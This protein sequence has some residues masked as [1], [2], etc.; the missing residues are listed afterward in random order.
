MKNN[1]LNRFAI[2]DLKTHKKD[3]MMTIVTIFIAAIIIMMI[4]FMTPLITNN[5]FLEY[6]YENGNY[7]YSY[8]MIDE[9][10]ND[11]KQDL[12]KTKYMI[13]GQE[14]TLYDLSY[15]IEYNYARTLHQEG[16]YEIEGDSSI[17]ATR[18][19]EGRMPKNKSE[20]AVKKSVLQRWGYGQKIGDFIQLSYIIENGYQNNQFGDKVEVHQFQVVGFLEETGSHSIIVSGF[21]QRTVYDS[22][23]I[24]TKDNEMIDNAD[25][26]LLEKNSTV[27]DFSNTPTNTVIIALIQT[28]IIIIATVLIYGLTL[29]SFE[30]KQKDYTLLRSIG[31]TQRQIYYV[32]MVQSLLLSVIP[33]IISIALIY[34][35]SKILPIL[36]SLPIALPF[37]IGNVLW[38]TFIILLLVFAS[39]FIP[40]RS[41]T[42]QS[43][44]GTFEGQEF[45]YFYYRYKKLHQLRPFYLAWRQLIA[46]KKKMITKIIMIIII[47]IMAFQIPS[48]VLF[49]QQLKEKKSNENI[50]NITIQCSIDTK[51]SQKQ[52]QEDFQNLKS[53]IQSMISYHYI[54]SQDSPN[55]YSI[56]CA[57]QQIREYYHLQDV[58]AG[59]IIVSSLYLDSENGNE[60]TKNHVSFLGNEYD[61]I[62]VI[63]SSEYA[64][65]LNVKD[66][67]KYQKDIPESGYSEIILSFNNV[68][69]KTNIL[70]NKAKDI[71]AIY[72]KYN[73]YSSEDYT[74]FYEESIISE[75]TI[76][77]L[78][79]IIV[80][81][82][83]YIYQF[84]FELLKQREDIGSYQLL[85]L[86]HKEIWQIYFYKSF[87]TIGIGYSLGLIYYIVD[88]YYRYQP[89]LKVQY[90]LD[91]QGL[92]L[93][94]VFGLLV[95]IIILLISLFPLRIIVK[96][97]A[98]VNKNA[99]E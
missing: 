76:Q 27:D 13:D 99:R 17:I 82:I 15:C 73:I 16:M 36:I 86:T 31:A 81:A 90:V 24:K 38:N 58:E 4:S 79:I 88:M 26:L 93:V 14:K 29:L 30:K 12:R 65:Y 34:I 37:S 21:S 60:K 53:N 56:Y 83:V 98:F 35:L 94:I 67:Q 59:Q 75:K 68:Q 45:Q 62:Q 69:E 80:I 84:V 85:G 8:S 39:F 40:A 63:D 47:T 6:Q 74:E 42:R 91:W 33:L 96:N 18:L 64:V 92:L 9:E 28:L 1:I 87:I 10:N 19:I 25:Q 48:H 55:R 49:N 95:V 22:I 54:S 57:N 78:L 50:N 41:V 72:E 97:D 20:I 3:S 11:K 44:T 46:V 51:L 23:Y 2:N 77:L 70:L 66:Y 7:T 52:M 32:I 89:S 5:H 71:A 61:V 43:L